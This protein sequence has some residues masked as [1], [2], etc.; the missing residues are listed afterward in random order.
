VYEDANAR[1]YYD[2]QGRQE[3][4]DSSNGPADGSHHVSQLADGGDEQVATTYF[5][6]ISGAGGAGGGE[7]E[8]VSGDYE[9]VGEGQMDEDGTAGEGGW[10]QQDVI[11]D[12]DG[13][14]VHGLANTGDG[15]VMFEQYRDQHQQWGEE[16]QQADYQADDDFGGATLETTEMDV[17]EEGSGDEETSAS[18]LES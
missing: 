3:V 11:V 1:D 12:S 14:P 5:E 6:D 2:A 7:E 9:A 10:Q 8:V 15:S 18:E 13:V 16:E 17:D 4:I